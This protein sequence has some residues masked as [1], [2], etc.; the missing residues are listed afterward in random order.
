MTLVPQLLILTPN[1]GSLNDLLLSTLLM[2][3]TASVHD[4]LWTYSTSLPSPRRKLQ[5]W[6]FSAPYEAVALLRLVL[7]AW[8]G[9]YARGSDMD[10]S[11][12]APPERP[13]AW[14]RLGWLVIDPHSDVVFAFAGSIAVVVARAVKEHY[15]AGVDVHQTACAFPSP[16]PSLLVSRKLAADSGEPRDSDDPPHGRLALSRL[17]R[18]HLRLPSPL[19]RPPPLPPSSLAPLSSLTSRGSTCLVFPSHLLTARRDIFVIRDSYS[20]IAR[21]K[22]AFKTARPF[23]VNRWPQ[24]AT[25]IAT[26]GWAVAAVVVGRATDVFK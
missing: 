13:S 7:P 12:V 23:K 22:H 10:L 8:L 25:A 24:V 17:G 4:L 5:A 18:P 11:S 1:L 6:V 21:P 15:K 19:V 16:P 14:K 9:G 3:L 26:I 20:S 2:L